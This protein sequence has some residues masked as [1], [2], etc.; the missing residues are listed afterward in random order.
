VKAAYLYNFGRFIE[1]PSSAPS[2]SAD[3]F[4]ICVLGEDPFGPSLE[5]SLAGQTVGRQRVQVARVTKAQSALACRILFISSSEKSRLN[6]ILRTLD[7]T[8]ILTVSD[9]PEFSE[10]GGMIHL[11]SV[12]NRVRFDVNLD[13]AEHAGL[14]VRSELLKVAN[15][16]TTSSS[17]GSE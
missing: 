16:V 9:M 12:S 6:D 15:S 3:S 13:T 11:V 4:F 10:R 8:A 7:G 5:K 14:G 17:G 1:W 2:S